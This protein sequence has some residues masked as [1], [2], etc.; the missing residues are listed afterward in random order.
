MSTTLLLLLLSHLS[1]FRFHVGLAFSCSVS[2]KRLHRTEDEDAVA[3]QST[4][5]RSSRTRR[6]KTGTMRSYNYHPPIAPAP[7]PVA[8]P[9]PA[10]ASADSKIVASSNIALVGKRPVISIHTKGKMSTKGNISGSKKRQQPSQSPH[11]VL[12]SIL[13]PSSHS[14][15]RSEGAT[16]SSSPSSADT[17]PTPN[18]SDKKRPTFEKPPEED[19]AAYDI[20]SVRAVRASNLER[21]RELW[22]NGKS[23]DACNPFG[24]SLL[25]MACRRGDYK[26]VHFMVCE[27]KV[28]TDRCDDFGRNPFHDALWTSSPNP[29]L[30]D[31]LIDHIEP[32]MLMAEDVRGNAPFA[33]ARREHQTK[34]I[35]FLEERREKLR[36]LHAAC[37]D[38][39]AVGDGPVKTS[40]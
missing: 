13:A 31:L 19:I 24:E 9:P 23:L 16:S 40:A 22:Q 15:E 38:A 11:D 29:E 39:A 14:V 20:E 8:V 1:F 30:L 3:Q 32:A 4:K 10:P 2:R 37:T 36:R 35:A 21:L 27:V 7:P 33:Y 18:A 34:W 17:S 26:V 28:R 25:H 12:L 6:E 5:K